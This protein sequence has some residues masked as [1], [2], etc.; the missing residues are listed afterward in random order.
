MN[1][2]HVRPL[3]I[4]EDTV[5]RVEHGN[6]PVGLVSTTDFRVAHLQMKPGDRLL[7]VT[8]GVTEAEN[9]E[10]ELFG[11]ERLEACC[12]GGARASDVQ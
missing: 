8:D 4:S 5:T 10:G 3:L 1:C 7:V 2:G 9:A 12:G 6:L 11:N